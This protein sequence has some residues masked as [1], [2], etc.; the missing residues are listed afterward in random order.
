[1]IHVISARNLHHV[2]VEF[3]LSGQV[4][5]HYASPPQALKI[6]GEKN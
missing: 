1:M 4:C 5:M 2:H 6:F 3:E